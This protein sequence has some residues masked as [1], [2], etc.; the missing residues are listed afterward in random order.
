MSNG[1]DDTTKR[2]GHYQAIEPLD[3]PGAAQLWHSWDPYLG[4]FV[5]VASLAAIDAATLEAALAD[6]DSALRRWTGTDGFTAQDVLHF[7]PG[8]EHEGA[9]V[10]LM[11]HVRARPGHPVAAAVPHAAGAT[12]WLPLAMAAL[13]I[14]GLPAILYV[15]ASGYSSATPPPPPLAIAST[16]TPTECM[17]ATS[18]PTAVPPATAPVRRAPAKAKPAAAP[19]AEPARR[20]SADVGAPVAPAAEPPLA[21]QVPALPEEYQPRGVEPGTVTATTRR[22]GNASTLVREWLLRNCHEVERAYLAAGRNFACGWMGVVIEGDLPELT[23]SY[24]QIERHLPTSRDLYTNR[25]VRLLCTENCIK[26][27]EETT[28]AEVY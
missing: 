18:T 27:S 12:S 5:V 15:L 13:L 24:T 25:R 22:M 20:K 6:L 16:P 8:N 14:L 11:P 21:V 28:Q 7:F 3:S 19:A 17:Q 2:F 9:F 23:V 4:R 26:L 1:A 10:V